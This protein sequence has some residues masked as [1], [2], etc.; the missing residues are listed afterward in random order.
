MC[1]PGFSSQGK[2]QSQ[3][4]LPLYPFLSYFLSVVFCPLPVLL[5]SLL[6]LFHFVRCFLVR[7]VLRE[8]CMHCTPALRFLQTTIPS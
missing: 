2:N 4:H 7:R 6:P 3:T 8:Q 1:T 5:S